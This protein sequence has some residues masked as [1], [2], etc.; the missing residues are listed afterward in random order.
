MNC[1]T[2]SRQPL[3]I[4]N[5]VSGVVSGSPISVIRGDEP[6]LGGRGLGA[7]VGLVSQ[8]VLTVTDCS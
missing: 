8:L 6:L 3:V 4:T 7:L 1:R 2:N 5:M